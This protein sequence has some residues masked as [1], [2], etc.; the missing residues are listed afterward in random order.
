MSSETSLFYKHRLLGKDFALGNYEGK[1][2]RRGKE[3][4]ESNVDTRRNT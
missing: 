1:S 4:R 3:Y 2:R